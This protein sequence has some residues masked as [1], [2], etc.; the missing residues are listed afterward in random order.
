MEEENPSFWNEQAA[1]AIEA[2]FKIQAR[3]NQAKN[4]I[5]FLGDG[6]SRCRP[7]GQA[8][9]TAALRSWVRESTQSRG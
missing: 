6:E 9:I 1:A 8:G 5:I 4:L 3:T 7:G 2:T